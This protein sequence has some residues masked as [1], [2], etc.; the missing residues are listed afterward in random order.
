MGIL[1]SDSAAYV[2]GT[3]MKLYFDTMFLD[4][5]KSVWWFL[6]IGRT[7]NTDKLKP[8]ISTL[9]DEINVMCSLY[10]FGIATSVICIFSFLNDLSWHSINTH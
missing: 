1:K 5:N 8:H 9:D 7:W 6:S 2:K 4:L 3:W 10:S